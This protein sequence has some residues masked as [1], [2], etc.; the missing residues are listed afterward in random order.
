MFESY[1]NL[2]DQIKKEINI[3]SKVG[4]QKSFK[5]PKDSICLSKNEKRYYCLV[6]KDAVKSPAGFPSGKHSGQPST[7]TTYNKQNVNWVA[8][9]HSQLRL[10]T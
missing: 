9:L 8:A 1:G 2:F 10:S 6:R 3:C 7:V 5:C 4:F